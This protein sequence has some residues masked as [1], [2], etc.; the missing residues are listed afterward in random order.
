MSNV[1]SALSGMTLVLME[2]WSPVM[3]QVESPRSG[4]RPFL[5]SSADMD[6]AKAETC[7]T[8]LT[9]CPGREA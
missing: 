2:P 3:A 4:Y 9:P 7:S 1:A 8:A 6:R 5:R